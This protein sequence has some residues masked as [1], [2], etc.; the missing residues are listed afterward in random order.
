M[1]FHDDDGTILALMKNMKREAIEKPP[2]YSELIR[3]YFL[4]I[5]LLTLR[6]M[7]S[8]SI[9]AS[10]N[11]ISAFLTSYV[12]KHYSEEISLS[13]L[14]S[15]LNYS[16][17]YVS[18]RFKEETGISFVHFLQSHRIRAACRMLLTNNK[19][20]PEIAELVGYHDVKF[21]TEQFKRQT[22]FTPLS[23]RKTK[24]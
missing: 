23:Y 1:T 3:C 5:I 21:F 4:E 15:E 19:S 18:K 8:A 6:R 17:P 7:D 14:A 10:C 11:T 13:A 16:L 12:A 2:L 24:K 20:I 22:G 9:A